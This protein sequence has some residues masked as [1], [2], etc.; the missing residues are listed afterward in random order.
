MYLAPPV[1]VCAQQRATR[2][3]DGLAVYALLDD[4]CAAV[5]RERTLA[6]AVYASRNN[7]SRLAN[8]LHHLYSVTDD[9]LARLSVHTPGSIMAHV[10]SS[11]SSE[12]VNG[13]G[14]NH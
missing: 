9:T 12:V 5:R 4:V 10:T 6:A 8:S 1:N 11:A 14:R 13:Q 7:D 2:A 3:H